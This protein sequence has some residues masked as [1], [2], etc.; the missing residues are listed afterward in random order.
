MQRRKVDVV[1]D[2]KDWKVQTG[3]IG[4]SRH[5]TLALAIRSAIDIAHSMGNRGTATD[6]MVQRVGGGFDVAW[7]YGKDPY[8]P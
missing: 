5:E 6:V 4:I 3:G 8:P 1:P 7:T 2:G